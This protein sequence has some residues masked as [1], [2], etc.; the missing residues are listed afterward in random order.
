METCRASRIHTFISNNVR[1]TTSYGEPP[2]LELFRKR[3]TK[4]HISVTSHPGDSETQRELIAARRTFKEQHRGHDS[5]RRLTTKNRTFE[6]LF[7]SDNGMTP[8]IFHPF[9]YW[10]FA[11]LGLSLPYRWGIYCTIGH[12]RYRIEK[13]VFHEVAPSTASAQPLEGGPS[14][15]GSVNEAPPRDHPLQPT[16]TRTPP[17][18]YEAV[19]PSFEKRKFCE[20][21]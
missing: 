20:E 11:L 7:V 19:C 14:G 15:G 12:V 13:T 1:T 6:K 16:P 2:S 4:L 21:V 18:A 8:W 5:T 3:Y 17:P 10:I 9:F